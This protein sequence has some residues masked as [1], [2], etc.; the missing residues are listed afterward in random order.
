MTRLVEIEEPAI[1]DRPATNTANMVGRFLAVVATAIPTV[2]GLMAIVQFDWSTTGLDSP[3]VTTAG[4][5]FRPWLAIGTLIIGLVALAA[6][7]GWDREYKLFI[8]ALLV[9]I[10]LVVLSANPTI[11]DVVLGD[12]M[13]WMH[14]IAGA[15]L[16][17]TG[18][19]R[20]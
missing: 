9:A 2:I 11:D 12:R 15:V 16:A 7:A 5:S 3:A 18:L 17:L 1:D 14:L 6:A 20:R 19:R 13:G 8:G 10:G 4:M